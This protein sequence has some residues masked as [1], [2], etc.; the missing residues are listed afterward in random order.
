MAEAKELLLLLEKQPT[1]EVISA[2]MAKKIIQIKGRN[3]SE[4]KRIEN[5]FA[6]TREML[7]KNINSSLIRELEAE[8]KQ[9]EANG[10]SLKRKPKPEAP[11]VK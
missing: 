2:D 10:G 1:Y 8:V 4:Q 3:P 6:E 7:V 9:A 5:M 11:E